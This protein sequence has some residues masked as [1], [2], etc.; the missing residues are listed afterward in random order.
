MLDVASYKIIKELKLTKANIIMSA[1]GKF[2]ILAQNTDDAKEKINNIKKEI[3][4]ELY[5]DYFG[6]LYLNLEYT[7]LNGEELGLQ[8]SKI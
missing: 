7:E 1:G 3:N 8:F 5:T 2:Y 6:D 4:R